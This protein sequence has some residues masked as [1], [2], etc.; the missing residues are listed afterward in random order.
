MKKI[1]F[2]C[3]GNICRSPIAEG[4]FNALMEKGYGESSRYLAESA[5]TNALEGLR[6]SEFS[7]KYLHDEWN[8]DISHIRSRHYLDLNPDDFDFLF[9]LTK[10]HKKTIL[11]EN[12]NLK[13]KTFTL[14]EYIEEAPDNPDI[15]D[16]YGQNYNIYKKCGT[17]IYDCVSRLVDILTF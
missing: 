4:V 3:T 17:E 11:S 1:L 7:V 2:I 15:F 13:N 12:P 8:I 5:G 9:A 16:P 10:N 14:K 6:P